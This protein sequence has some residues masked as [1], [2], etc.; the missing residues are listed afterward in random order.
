MKKIYVLM[1][2]W[3]LFGEKMRIDPQMGIASY[4]TTFGHDVSWVLVSEGI[5]EIQETTLTDVNVFVVPYSPYS[6]SFLNIVK[7]VLSGFRR[8]SFE[9]K[10]FKQGRYNMIFVRGEIF[11]GLLALYIKRRYNV[12]FVF[13]IVNPPEQNWETRK[14]YFSK[15]KYILYFFSKI[16]AYLTKYILFRADLILPTTQW[17]LEDLVKRGIERSK[18]MPFPNGI[19]IE[20]FLSGKEEEIRN[21][22]ELEDSNVIIYVGTMEKERH[23]DVLIQAFLKVK[24]NRQNVKLLMLG[25]GRDKSNLEKLAKNLGIKEDVI[26]TGQV[27]FQEVPNFIAAA[28]IGVSPIPPRD[29]FKL[30][31]PIKMFEYMAMGKPVVANEEIPEQ[32]EVIEECCGG[33]LVKFEAESFARGIIELLNNSEK[34]KVMGNRGREWVVNNR[35]YAILARRL[36]EKYFEILRIGIRVQDRRG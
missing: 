2:L 12:P 7:K 21:K 1:L 8:L 10:I 23:L 31:S 5:K 22:Y 13:E 30:S 20:G 32:K 36:E 9:F 15:H 6:G 11:N 35:S 34:A 14:I 18:M 16:E 4:I 27:Y 24:E 29:F 33:I 17:M 3:R 19:R 26:F 25:D 28:D